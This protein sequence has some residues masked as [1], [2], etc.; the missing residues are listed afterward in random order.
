MNL[1]TTLESY[2]VYE[3]TTPHEVIEKHEENQRYWRFSLFGSKKSKNFQLNP[4]VD[5]CIGVYMHKNKN[6]YQYRLIMST[7]SR[8]NN[9][10]LYFYKILK[11]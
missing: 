7:N 2:D 8:S 1:R 10:L 9:L 3:G 6:Q 5:S 4:F 11:Y